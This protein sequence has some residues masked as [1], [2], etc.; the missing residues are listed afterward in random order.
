MNNN[1]VTS[2]KLIAKNTLFLYF[3]MGLTMLVSLYTSRIILEVLGIEDFGIYNVVGGIV[4]MFGFLNSSLSTAIQRFFSFEL[5]RE[6]LIQL[7]KVFSLSISIQCIICLIIFIL[8]ETAGLW[9]LNNKLS[10]PQ[11]RLNAANWC[12]QLSIFT[13]IINVISLPYNAL[14]IAHEKMTIYAYLSI[15]EVI[16]KLL[17]VYF[18]LVFSID[19]L[20]LY[21]I[22]IFF[23]TSLIKSFYMIYCRIKFEESK[24]SFF[25]DKFMFKEMFSFSG[26]MLFG[27]FSNMLC[28]QGI[29][30]LLNI[31]FG[32]IINAARGIAYQVQAAIASF[33]TNIMTAVQ[34]PLI[35]AYAQQNYSYMYKLVYFSSKGTFLLLFIMSIPI[36]IDTNYVLSLWLKN[37]P[38]YVSIFTQLVLID[39]LITSLYVPIA[40]ISQASAKMKSY[41]LSISI[42]FILVFIGAYLLFKYNFN[43]TSAFIWIIIMS[44]LG[45]IIRIVIMKKTVSFPIKPYIN[46]V[47]LPICY[48]SIIYILIH[49][50][51]LETV[52]IE[53][54]IFNFIIRIILAWS[55]IIISAWF[56]FLNKEE[57]NIITKYFSNIKLKLYN[58]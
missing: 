7:K 30:M 36:F 35:K 22:F 18:L 40:S 1:S 51:F 14:I 15:I 44:L 37:V 25:W 31:F 23:V 3:R 8:A 33:S 21:S 54:P 24:F 45:L 19:K 6:D 55:I 29:N 47:L 52:N 46:K 41:Q 12:Y 50:L 43:A 53:A 34:P 11:D 28:V 17:I 58:Q 20:I 38:D 13:F 39:I 2:N 5:G 49:Y 57:R 32:P 26:W 4:V 27:T 16:L 42:Q 48:L 56:V 10:I 9:F